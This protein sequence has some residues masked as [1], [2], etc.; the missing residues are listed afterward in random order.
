VI[1]H[2]TAWLIV[3]T[4]FWLLLSGM[5]QPLLLVFGVLSIALVLWVIVR[6]DKVDREA[7]SI[8]FS[9][10]FVSYVFWLLGQIMLSSGQ[11]I[12]I[13]W[14]RK[15]ALNPALAV[16]EFDPEL[17]GGRVLYAN[18]LTLTPGTLSVDLNEHSITVHALDSQ[19]IVE[20]KE[21]EMQQR[22][23]KARN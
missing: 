2:L 4:A 22:I 19:S 6:M 17:K 7:E 21:G 12:K 14:A 11:V 9:P 1:K 10:Y 16:L 8:A 18:S 15:I 20:L 3:L 13:I 23:I 5:F